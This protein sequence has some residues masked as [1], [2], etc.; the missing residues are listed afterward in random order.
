[1]NAAHSVRAKKE[2]H[3]EQFCS[4]P[5]C[6]WRIRKG[7]GTYIGPCKSTKHS[8]E[9]SLAGRQSRPEQLPTAA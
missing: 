2:A 7:D 9:G 4:N 8:H 1:M 3:P 6:L 5:R